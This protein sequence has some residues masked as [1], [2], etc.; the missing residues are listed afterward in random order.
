MTV[1]IIE[2]SDPNHKVITIAT[3]SKEEVE[4]IEQHIIPAAD[5]LYVN[6]KYVGRQDVK[7]AT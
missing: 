7:E 1:R 5:V 6:G 4:L 2:S 3:G